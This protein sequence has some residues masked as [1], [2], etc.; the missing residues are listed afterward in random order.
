MYKK[1]LQF[2]YIMLCYILY[3]N[4]KIGVHFYENKYF[5]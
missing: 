4:K 1:I 3:I 2:E 5:F